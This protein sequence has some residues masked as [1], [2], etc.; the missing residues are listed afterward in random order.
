MQAF[1]A[2]NPGCILEDFVRW[3]SP[4]DWTENG[5]MSG[6]DSSPVR[7]QLST[8]MQKEGVTISQFLYV[9]KPLL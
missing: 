7:G 2:A 8:R 3:H 5:N 6:D 4:P 1:K 9:V